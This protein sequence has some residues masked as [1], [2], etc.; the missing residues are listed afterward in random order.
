[1]HLACY[2]ERQSG[3]KNLSIFNAVWRYSQFPLGSATQAPLPLIPLVFLRLPPNVSV[4]FGRFVLATFV[5][6]HDGTLTTTAPI[7]L[8]GIPLGFGQGGVTQRGHDFVSRALGIGQ[9]APQRFRHLQSPECPNMI[10][11]RIGTD[12]V[13]A[14]ARI[15]ESNERS[16]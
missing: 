10:Y 9:Q 5:E 4:W 13:A 6:L 8:T 3:C 11:F 16:L 7:R 1:M 14:R 2:T 12:S 15:R